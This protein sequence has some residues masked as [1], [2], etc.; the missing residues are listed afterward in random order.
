MITTPM[1]TETAIMFR[2]AIREKRLK[3]RYL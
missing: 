1:S 2:C 3:I